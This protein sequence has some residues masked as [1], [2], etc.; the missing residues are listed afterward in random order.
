LDDGRRPF[1]KGKSGV[2]V[3]VP[4]KSKGK[5]KQ[6]QGGQITTRKTQRQRAFNKKNKGS[7]KQTLLSI[8]QKKVGEK[9]IHRLDEVS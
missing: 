3:L 1:V 2:G 5:L 9:G 8:G 4:T 6:K 7:K